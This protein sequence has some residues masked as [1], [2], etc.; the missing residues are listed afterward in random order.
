M[1]LGVWIT[2]GLFMTIAAMASGS[3]F[4]GVSGVWRVVVIVLSVTYI[5]AT[6]DG[7]VFALLVVALVALLIL[8]FRA[9]RILLTSGLS[10]ATIS[11]AESQS[12]PIQ[13]RVIKPEQ[14]DLMPPNR[15]S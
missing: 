15:I 2:G 3:G 4:I 1:L 14:V 10:S 13:G 5:L 12:E 11:S 7:S 9:S 8:G 6:F